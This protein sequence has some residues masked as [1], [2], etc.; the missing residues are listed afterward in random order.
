M[1]SH[2]NPYHHSITHTSDSPAVLAPT[3]WSVHECW[4]HLSGKRSGGLESPNYSWTFVCHWL[5]QKP[6]YEWSQSAWVSKRPLY[7]A[8][9][10]TS[11]MLTP[12]SQPKQHKLKTTVSIRH[13]MYKPHPMLPTKELW[14]HLREFGLE[15]MVLHLLFLWLSPR[16]DKKRPHPADCRIGFLAPVYWRHLPSLLAT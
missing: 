11:T 1:A 5:C 7:C 13:Y 3:L 14:F 8:L 6:F 10:N 2:H 15:R 4:I 12:W 9:R 16:R